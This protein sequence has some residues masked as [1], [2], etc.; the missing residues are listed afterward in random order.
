MAETHIGGDYFRHYYC[1]SFLSNCENHNF[2]KRKFSEKTN[3][4]T[5][6]Q[7]LLSEK[8]GNFLE[9]SFYETWFNIDSIFCGNIQYWFKYWFNIDSIFCGNI[10]YWFKYWFNINSIFCGNIQYWFKYWF[11]IDS[12]FCGNIE[13]ILIQILIQ[14]WFDFLW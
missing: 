14:Y 10:Q 13:S 8:S 2:P 4:Q 5:N 9:C 11:N 6:K 1:E 3:K 7:R 12:I